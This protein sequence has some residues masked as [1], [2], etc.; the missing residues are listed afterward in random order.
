MPYTKE[1]ARNRSELYTRILDAERIALERDINDAKQKMQESGSFD[2]NKPIRDGNGV[3]LSYEDPENVRNDGTPVS[4]EEEY[5][6][7][8]LSVTQKSSNTSLFEKYLGE[9]SQ[10]TEFTD[11]ETIAESE[12]PTAEELQRL[13]DTL[14]DEIDAQVTLN[15]DLETE[16][17]N[18]QARIVELND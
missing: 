8:R 4:L 16:I 1:Q 3:L 18:L 9:K 11:E 12:T 15:Q 5:Q 2:A 6:Y 7:V 13:R 14:K 17:G 10:F